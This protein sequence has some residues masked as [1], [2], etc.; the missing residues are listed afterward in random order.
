MRF[1]QEIMQTGGEVM[2]LIFACSLAAVFLIAERLL[3]YHRAQIEVSEFLQGLF[4][5]LKRNRVVEA[6]AICDE[7][8]GPV[9]RV[10]RA[11]ILRG[12]RTEAELRQ[13]V[14]EA[15]LME[16]PRLE[17]NLKP[18]ATLAHIAPLLGLLGTV[19]GMINAFQVMQE[20]GAFVSTKDLAR[21]ISQALYCTAGGLVVSIPALAFYN[22]LVGRVE[23]LTFDMQKAGSEMIWFLSRHKLKFE[24]VLAARLEV[25]QAEGE[26]DEKENGQE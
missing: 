5:V 15:C 11:A 25:L 7:T 22:F 2:W 23:S 21:H 4:N 16:L 17:R 14:E 18:L 6:V 3:C 24:G 19:I 13:A 9:A 1:I 26:A 8:P 12:D 10:L 20:G